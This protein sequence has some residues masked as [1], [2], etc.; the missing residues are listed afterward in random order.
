MLLR[1]PSDLWR[2]DRFMSTDSVVKVND[3]DNLGRFDLGWIS[4][5]RSELFGLAIIY[6]MVY[7][8]LAD[9]CNG[10]AR[11]FVDETTGWAAFAQGFM[12]WHGR[13]AVEIFVFLSGLGLYYSFVKDS[14]LKRYFSRRYKRILIPYAIVGTIF[15]ALKDLILHSNGIKIFVADISFYTLATRSVHSIWFIGLL[16]FAYLIFPWVFKVIEKRGFFGF[17]VI[18][19]LSYALPE[20]LVLASHTIGANVSIVTTRLPLFIYGVYFA[21][22]VREGRRISWLAAVPIILAGFAIKFLTL[23]VPFDPIIERY[24]EGIYTL[25]LIVF[26]TAVLRLISGLKYFNIGLRYLGKYSIELYLVTVTSRNILKDIGFPGYSILVFAAY[27]TFALVIAPWFSKL[28]SWF[29]DVIVFGEDAGEY[30]RSMVSADGSEGKVRLEWIDVLK[31]ILIFFVVLGHS[32][33]DKK[34]PDTLGYYIYAFHMPAFFIVSGM[35]F[36]LQMKSKVWTIG[37]VFKNKARQILWPYLT[38]A[39]GALVIWFIDYRI[40]THADSSFKRQIVGMFISNGKYYPAHPTWFLLVLFLTTMIFAVI[41]LW[42]SGSRNTLELGKMTH[43]GER[44][45]LT[46]SVIMGILGYVITIVPGRFFCFPW[47]G[48]VVPMAVL[49]F[50]VGFLVIKEFDFFRFFFGRTGNQ[51]VTFGFALI[52][53]LGAAYANGKISMATCVYN[54][55]ILFIY[56]VLSLTC[57]MMILSMWLP[58]FRLFKMIGRNTIV[59]LAWHTPLTWTLMTVSDRFC[60]LKETHPL[61]S[62]VIVFVIMIPVAYLVER[63]CPVILGRKKKT[64]GEKA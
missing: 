49:F 52:S 34:T 51:I 18:L 39:S 26:L 15:W 28:C 45:V 8:Y 59:I 64:G 56:E 19:L 30:N 40:L 29:S 25:G 17:A 60:M 10:I 33:T 63:W 42:A 21:K 1:K 48:E 61:V 50:A 31:C 57:A 22:F 36:F 55:L 53:G 38:L 37:D 2:N 12:A 32:T 3:K 9:V 23:A 43:A 62:G 44:S 6:V 14:S 16:L 13:S 46:A 35:T 47:Y 27:L 58:K 24:L 4:K 5:Y 11:G 54:N 41:C 20:V 7:H